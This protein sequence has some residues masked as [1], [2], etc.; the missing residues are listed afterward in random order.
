MSAPLPG[1][2]Y[3]IPRYVNRYNC[4]ARSSASM[5]LGVPRTLATLA[6]GVMNPCLLIWPGLI[7]VVGPIARDFRK[8]AQGAAMIG[9]AFLRSLAR[10]SPLPSRSRQGV[11][12]EKPHHGRSP[13]GGV[14][15]CVLVVFAVGE[16]CPG[17]RDYRRFDSPS[18]LK[19]AAQLVCS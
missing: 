2:R 13:R 12:N 6:R 5:R 18:E 4:G 10:I 7:G 17:L 11:V 8:P 3:T 1:A 14:H 9:L 15:R 19:T 16:S